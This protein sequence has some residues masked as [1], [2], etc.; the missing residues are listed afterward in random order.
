MESEDRKF[1]VT[2]NRILDAD[3]IADVQYHPAG[4]PTG[5]TTYLGVDAEGNRQDEPQLRKRSELF[6]VFKDPEKESIS[7]DGDEA[8]KAWKNFRKVLLVNRYGIVGEE[9]EKKP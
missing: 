1:Y 2:A 8:D 7:L 6:I 5:M 4:S 9:E 3:V